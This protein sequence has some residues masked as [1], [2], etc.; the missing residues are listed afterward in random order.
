MIPIEALGLSGEFPRLWSEYEVTIP[1]PYHYVMR[2]QG[3]QQFD[4]S[5]SKEIMQNYSIREENGTSQSQ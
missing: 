1:P 3:D 5:T 4:V 2:L